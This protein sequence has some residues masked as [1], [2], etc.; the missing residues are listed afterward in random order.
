MNLESIRMA[1]GGIL[2]NR[3][4]SALTMLGILIGVASVIVL[5]AVGAG[6]AEASR[7]RLEALGSN[8]LT[9][10]P[11][12]LNLPGVTS[13][14]TRPVEITDGDVAALSDKNQ[15]PNV[16]DVVPTVNATARMI[17]DGESTSPRSIIGTTANFS[18]VRN[19]PMLAGDFFT[20]EEYDTSRRVMVIG[21]TT[22]KNL[23]GEDED[24][25]TLV[26][27]KVK[28]GPT[29]FTIIGVFKSKGS[30]GFQDQDD[31]AVLPLT[32]A[33]TTITGGTKK[34]DGLTVRATSRETTD[35]AQSEVQNVLVSRHRGSSTSDYLVLNQAS[36]QATQDET[37]KTFTTLLGAVAAIS[38]LV[39]GIGVMN[40]M[41]V[42]V[43]ER[44]REIGIRKAIGARRIHI[45]SQFLTEAVLLSMLGGIL[46]VAVG[47]VGSRFNIVGTKPVV[48]LYSIILA[49]AVAVATG[50]FFGLFPANRA[51]KLR[52]I[53]ALRHE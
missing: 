3:M 31:V 42:T 12:G 37:N 35:A 10:L 39:G 6:S 28:F 48:Q 36:I 40:I 24:P 50:L 8:T 44:T 2:A 41:L 52:P 18:D 1:V 13:S 32:T 43:T 26:G 21:T 17:L 25:A 16:S 53:D 30:N 14:R 22:A 33:R 29:G 46:G 9:V 27:R 7:K 20:Q 45:V 49:F 38:L 15:A 4:R 23:I 47:V 11:G 19:Y 34:V 5:I 51:A